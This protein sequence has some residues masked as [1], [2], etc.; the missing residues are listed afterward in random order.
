MLF[1]SRVSLQQV[2][3]K[4][5]ILVYTPIVVAF[6]LTPK[7]WYDLHIC[8]QMFLEMLQPVNAIFTIDTFKRYI[9]EKWLSRK[10]HW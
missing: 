4:N 2:S 9:S 7:N 8:K 1:L 3:I 10:L 6:Y 5:Q